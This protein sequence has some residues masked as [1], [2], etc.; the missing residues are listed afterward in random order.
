[1]S[2]SIKVWLLLKREQKKYAIFILILMFFAMFLECL[3]VGIILPLFSILLKGNIDTSFF[4]YFFTF[5]MPTEKNLIYIGLSITLIVFLIKNLALAF[6]LWQQTKFIR[7]LELEFTNR[8]FKYYLKSDYIFFLQKNSAHLYRNLTGVISSFIDY[9]NRHMVFLSEIIVFMGIVFILFYVD[10]LGTTVILFSVGVVSFIIYISTIRKISFFGKERNILSGE[11]NK[12]LLQGMASAKDV[13]ILDREEDLIHQVDKNL[14]KITRLK[15][16]IKFINGLPRFSFEMLIVCVF[17]VL[18]FVMI[19]AKRDM[20]DIIQYLGVFAVASF[21]IVPG[22]SRILTS[23]QMIRYQEP[24][25]K[26]LLQEFDSKDNSYAKKNYQPKDLSTPLKFQRE[27]NLTNICFSYPIRKEF[28]LSKISMTVKKGD[29]VGII[30]E[31]GSGKSTLINLI[32]GLLKPSEGKVEVDELNINSNLP[33]WY[34]KIGYVPQ[35]VYLTDDT[36]RK[37]IAFGLREDNID[38]ALIKLAVEKASLNKFLNELSNGLETIVG[39]KG[40]RLSGGQ[41]QRIGIARA[42]YR[43]PEILVLD[44]ATSSL[45]QL[46]EKKI[47][48]SI[49][50]LKRKKTLIIIT[51]RLV[52]VKNCDKIFFIEEGKITKQG[53]P[54]EILNYN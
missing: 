14:F 3:S 13:K 32:I 49:Q 40:I 19:G 25:V 26:L 54:E 15:H 17:L 21:R 34:K 41:Q 39:E 45:D 20:I 22:A 33:E 47:M 44:E 53:S 35:S 43:D 9:I 1:M 37:N 28:S 42:L 23:Y 36:I 48:Q 52:T 16:M 29:F 50:F 38:D 10:F 2:L 6:N 51:H 11:L 30:G 18:V 24:A 31:T 4:S 46:T 5:G 12:H 8:L 27:I 7:K